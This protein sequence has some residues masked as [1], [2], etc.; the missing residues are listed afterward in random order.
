MKIADL[1]TQAKARYNAMTPEQ[2]RAHDKAQLESLIRGLMP[3]GDP[4]LD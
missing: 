3:T 2:R 1:V 4:R